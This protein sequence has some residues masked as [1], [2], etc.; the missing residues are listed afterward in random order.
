MVCPKETDF[1]TNIPEVFVLAHSQ[2]VGVQVVVLAPQD[3]LHQRK[4]WLPAGALP[5]LL[6]GGLAM[7]KVLLVCKAA[8]LCTGG[9]AK[10]TGCSRCS[11]LPRFISGTEIQEKIEISRKRILRAGVSL[12]LLSMGAR[13]HRRQLI[14]VWPV[15]LGLLWALHSPSP[16]TSQH[17]LF[18][19]L[20]PRAIP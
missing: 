13:S 14:P 20:F 11:V 7:V 18:F 12:S 10:A 5:A 17:P 8:K 1:C 2:G 15:S 6:A 16:G 4:V 3:S 9:P 19:Q